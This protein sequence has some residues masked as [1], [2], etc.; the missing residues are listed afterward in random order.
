MGL[1]SDPCWRR[2]VTA[3]VRDPNAD[4]YS[5]AA[6]GWARHGNT[7]MM[8]SSLAKLQPEQLVEV[9][10]AAS[11][12]F[13]AASDLAEENDARVEPVSEI[14]GMRNTLR[15]IASDAIADVYRFEGQPFTGKTVA[16][17]M[18]CQGAAI[19]ALA[20]VVERLL[21]AEADATTPEVSAP[22]GS[23][24][25]GTPPSTLGWLGA[26]PMDSAFNVNVRD[27]GAS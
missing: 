11:I 7:G 26:G 10:L 16:E 24:G 22:P 2:A 17:Y 18:G 20:R 4:T 15:M 3:F 1:P 21:P 12:L 23:A 8:R 9:K 13:S 27:G 6:W 5:S 25:A 14:E 19:Q